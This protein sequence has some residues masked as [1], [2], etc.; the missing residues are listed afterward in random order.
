[1]NGMLEVVSSAD[2]RSAFTWRVFVG[3]GHRHDAVLESLWNY[4]TRPAA[5]YAG[6]RW[7]N[8]LGIVLSG[9][10]P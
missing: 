8:S 5:K 3:K 4:N 7:A 1:M 6:R 2:G 10:S 9:E